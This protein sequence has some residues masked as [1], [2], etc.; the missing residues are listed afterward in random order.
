[1]HALKKAKETTAKVD[2][3]TTDLKK[4]GFDVVTLEKAKEAYDAKIAAAEKTFQNGNVLGT[5]QL[6]SEANTAYGLVKKE[7]KV[8][9]DEKKLAKLERAKETIEEKEKRLEEKSAEMKGKLEKAKAKIEETEEKLKE[10][11][12]KTE[13]GEEK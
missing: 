6:L 11:E 1:M 10:K 4:K 9:K 13:A 8:T 2:K 12:A 7:Y 5:K 3:S